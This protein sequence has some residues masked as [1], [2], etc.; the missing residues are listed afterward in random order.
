MALVS[1]KDTYPDYR[2]TFSDNSLSHI[3][4]YSVYADGD[5]KVGSVDDGLFDDTTGQFRYLVVDTGSWIFGKKVLLPIG[6]AQFDNA[7]QR[8]NVNGLTKSQVEDLPKYSGSKTVDYDHEENVRGVYREAAVGQSAPVEGAAYTRDTYSYDRD[9][10]LYDMPETSDRNQP[11]RLYEERLIADKNRAKTG[12]VTIG[13]RVETETANVSIPVEKERVVI[14]RSTPT[15]ASTATMGQT[16]EHA[17]EDGEV[18]R[19]EVYEETANVRKEAF[20]R[21]EVNV[22]KEVEQETVNKQATV[23]REELDVDSA[24]G[25]TVVNR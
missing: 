11:I 8:V 25:T 22:R 24:D 3:D 15:G 10:D 4:E 13:K 2:S 5:D 6:R 19:M 17:F 20:V 18:A 14:E 12:D 23:R 16:P 21:E 1:L 7:Q 9:A